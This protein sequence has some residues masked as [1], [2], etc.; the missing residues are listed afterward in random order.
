MDRRRFVT[1]GMAAAA[2]VQSTLM[3]QDSLQTAIIP[4]S[5]ERIPRI[6]LG[7]W[8]VFDVGE[9]AAARL[10]LLETLRAF[11]GAGG[12][13][14]DT[15][16]MYGTAESVIGDLV[17]EGNLRAGVWLATKVWTRGER[18]GI[19]QLETSL[20]RLRAPVVELL[21]VHNLLDWKVHL[22]TLR[23]WK[24]QGRTRYVGVTH[25]QASAFDDLARVLKAEPLDFVQVN[26]SLD[27]PE[28]VQRILPLCAE[29][30]V[31][32]LANRPFG[33]GGSFARVRG[34]PLP[35]WVADHG[36]T[37]WAQFLLRWVLAHEAVTCAIPGTGNPR[38]V[39]D[40]LDAA[41]GSALDATVRDR[42]AATWRGL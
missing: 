5:G 3:T 29:R 37:S 6:G 42:L 39:R 41:R 17:A 7:T 22:R 1:D 27:E 9:D 33:G 15:S 16:P 19:G 26:V 8:Q 2:L 24:E 40:N 18:D 13:V 20:R 34:T 11:T 35:R 38:H 31:A 32:V 36:I 21:Q 4:S 28:A 23:A 25:Y 10:R 30:G 14:V 12:C